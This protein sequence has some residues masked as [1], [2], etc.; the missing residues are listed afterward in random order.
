MAVCLY[1][2]YYKKNYK[3]A[4]IYANQLILASFSPFETKCKKLID[5]YFQGIE[6][7]LDH[8]QECP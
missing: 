3:K 2:K 5:M 7:A 1:Q 6:V 4:T 8:G